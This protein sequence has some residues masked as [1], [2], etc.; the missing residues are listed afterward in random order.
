MRP[1]GETREPSFTVI[2]TPARFCFVFLAISVK[3]HEATPFRE[4]SRAKSTFLIIPIIHPHMRIGR[5]PRPKIGQ[6]LADN[7]R[8]PSRLLRVRRQP[9]T[10]RR[11]HVGRHGPDQIRLA[12]FD[13]FRHRQCVPSPYAKNQRFCCARAL[14]GR[15]YAPSGHLALPHPRIK[16]T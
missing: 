8:Q 6:H 10:I 5:K 1:E 16:P 4:T 15:L 2:F 9:G 3:K 12:K 14:R 11:S 13:P 7:R